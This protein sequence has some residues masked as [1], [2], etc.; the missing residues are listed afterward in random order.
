MG[1]TFI[2][3]A[4]WHIG[5]RFKGFE[6]DVARPLEEARLDIIDRLGAIAA[7]AGARHAL[8][9]GD[10]FDSPAVADKLVRQALERMRRQA[11]VTW[12]LLPG[13]HDPARQGSVWQRVLDLMPDGCMGDGRMGD[14]RMAVGAAGSSGAGNV[15][16]LTEA[17]PVEIEPGVM[18]LPAPLH[19]RTSPVDPTAWFG[20]CPTP[21]GTIRIGLAHGSTKLDF[22]SA[23]AN[24]PIDPQG[25]VRHRLDYL[26][27]G[28][29]HGVREVGPS[30]WYSGTPEPDG[31]DDNGQGYAL[32]VRIPGA[33]L[34]SEVTPVKTAWFDWRE[35][36]HDLTRAEPAVFDTILKRGP[37]AETGTLASVV[38]PSRQLL[39][40]TLT[41]RI[42]AD[43]AAALD[44]WR[45][46]TEA[47][48]RYTAINTAGVVRE[49]GAGAISR[50]E[51]DPHL[52]PITARLR[53]IEGG[54]GTPE[55]RTAAAAIRKLVEH[56]RRFREAAE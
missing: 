7:D 22:G 3:S 17:C 24:V 13:N 45:A 1:I 14:G 10:V 39:R 27:L 16:L 25:V 26:A 35:M 11:Q 12:W 40:L 34:P 55:A 53:L 21:H 36:E 4:D 2:H 29:W 51:C 20:G 56:E 48:L 47:T 33:G 19:A 54:A 41:G 8:I 28:D 44:T 50:L 52:G 49:T 30:A 42:D 23:G 37:T 38:P 31:F 43:M 15:R 32:V 46:Q 9:A 18:V 6:P 5:R